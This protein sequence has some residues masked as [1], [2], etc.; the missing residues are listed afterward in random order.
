MNLSGSGTIS[1]NVLIQDEV[2]IV[3]GSTINLGKFTVSSGQRFTNNNILIYSPADAPT[4]LGS[5]AGNGMIVI[6][7][8]GVTHATVGDKGRFELTGSPTSIITST[9]FAKLYE[10]GATTSSSTSGTPT[11]SQYKTF[12]IAASAP[13]RLASGNARVAAGGRVFSLGSTPVPVTFIAF[14]GVL[15]GNAALISWA[16][17]MEFNNKEF[18]VEASSDAV[19]FTQVASVN[20][21]G[22]TNSLSNYSVTVTNPLKYYRLKQVD[23]D[24]VSTYS[25]I[26][27]VSGENI[28]E[29]SVFP[30]PFVGN[31]LYL[32]YNG[33]TEVDGVIVKIYDLNEKVHFEASLNFFGN[34]VSKL[35]LTEKLNNG[36]YFVSI[37]SQT[38][39][40][41]QK[42][43]VE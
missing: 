14:D 19:N 37:Q 17:S 21:V 43:L 8:G 6:G 38:G 2:R 25:K 12:N 11:G 10:Y 28:N 35:Q 18:I 36:I 34:E 9:S 23:F 4:I 26:I 31:D 30:N 22:T 29:F 33:S 27:E 16:T 3:P 41:I 15:Q 32:N 1:S 24:G 13:A 5:L 42:L 39:V 40:K 7:T 20:G